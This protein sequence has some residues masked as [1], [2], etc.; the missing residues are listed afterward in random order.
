MSPCTFDDALPR[1]LAHV[2]DAF[3]GIDI[4]KVRFIRTRPR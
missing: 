4:A 1:A 3:A 2:R